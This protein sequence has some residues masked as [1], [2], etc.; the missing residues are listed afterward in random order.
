M[1]KFFKA[2]LCLFVLFSSV[3]NH[4][5]L[6]E[7][8]IFDST[9]KEPLPG[10]NVYLDGTSLSTITDAEGN[11]RLNLQNRT[12][13]LV[14]SFIGYVTFKIENPS[15]YVNK[16]LR[17]LLVEESINLDEVVI[18]KGPFSRRQMMKVFREQFLGESKAGNSCRIENEQDIILFYDVS[19]NTLNASARNPLRIQNKYLDY[20]VNFDL[21]DFK[22]KYNFKSLQKYNQVSSYFS[23]TTFYKDLKKRKNVGKRRSES[24]YGSAQHFAYTLAYAAWEKEKIRLFV[25]GFQVNP[26]EYFKVIDTMGIKKVTLIKEPQKVMP[27]LNI[28]K[29]NFNI[30]YQKDKQSIIEF[31]DKVIYVDSNGN[32]NPI[33][34]ILYGGYIGTLKAGD[35]LP[36]DYF[37]NS[38]EMSK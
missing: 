15:E 23:G 6:I 8:R 20:Y 22:V 12:T 16:K 7:G 36:V 17:I 28:R 21:E 24:F 9:T 11:F 3:K 31:V 2:L 27:S 33:Y 14:V 10:A 35:L 25:N 18:G 13:T 34:G 5:Q 38:K 29:T 37:Q 1:I 26:Q 30:L 32:Y 19:D 4:A